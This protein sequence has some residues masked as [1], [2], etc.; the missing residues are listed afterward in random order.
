MTLRPALADVRVD[1]T[2]FRPA[3]FIERSIDNLRRAMLLGLHP[4]GRDPRRLPLRL[5]DRARQPAGHPA[6]APRPRCWSSISSAAPSTRWCSPGSSSRSARW[7]TTPSSTSRTSLRRLRLNRAGGAPQ[8]R[9]SRSSST[10]RSRCGAPSSTR[11]PHRR[12]R[13]PPGVL[14]PGPRRI[15]LPAAGARPTSSRS[16]ASLLV[17]LTVTPALCLLLLPGA[18]VEHGERRRSCGCSSA[19]YR[20]VLPAFIAQAAN[21]PS[22]SCVVAMLLGT[23]A[24]FPL[25]GEEFLPSFQETDFLMHW[26]EKPGTSLD[27]MRRITV[28]RE[29]GAAGH[30]RRPELRRPHRPG[31]GGRRGGRAELHGALDQHRPEGRLRH[32]RR[33]ASR[34]SWTATRA[35]TATC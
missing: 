18:S 17:A 14:P 23:A 19:R 1:S 31:R 9:L 34:K 26:V 12:P 10:R 33:A 25:L 5:A 11:T 35:S 28:Q 30:P 29:P 16:L 32:H 6:V 22:A 2:I 20:A 7:W 13:V 3:T 24:A 4:R 8:P 27:A 21:W 15:V